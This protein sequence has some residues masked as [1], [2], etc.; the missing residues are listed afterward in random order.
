MMLLR[1]VAACTAL[2]SFAAAATIRAGT[3]LEVR[4]DSKI[5]SVTSKPGDPVEAVVIVPVLDGER[6]LVPAGTKISGEVVSVQNPAKPEERATVELSFRRLGNVP[7]KTRVIAVDNAR[8]TVDDSGHIMGILASETLS[9]QM[10]KGVRKVSE[11]D[12]ALGV[13]LGIA[14][15]ALIGQAEGAIEYAPGVEMTV[16]L[17][18][19]VKWEHTADAPQLAPIRDA[20]ALHQ[21]VNALP[22]RTYAQNPRAPSDITSLMFVATE[23]ELTDAFKTAGWHTAHDLNSESLLETVRAI[24]EMRGYKEAPVSILTLDGRP[25]DLVFQ[26]STNTFA[27][28]HHMRLWRTRH[29]WSDKLVWVAAATHDVAIDFSQDSSTFIHRIDPRIDRE[30]AKI[31]SDLLY[32]GRVRSLALVERPE[33]PKRTK[34]ATGDDMVTDGRMAVV[35]L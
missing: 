16:R 13:L 23:Q 8:E 4:L 17:T 32:T 28:R 14:K 11:R 26:K 25:P 20:E 35:V 33:V 9:A 3:D 7:V 22:V 2:S 21:L 24:A 30:R 27:K 12:A 6:V 1:A 34:N 10:D 19:P 18:A 5:S 29:S 15:G 31:V